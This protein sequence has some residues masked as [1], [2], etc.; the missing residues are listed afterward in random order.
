MIPLEVYKDFLLRINKNDINKNISVPRGEF[1]LLFNEQRLLWLDIAIENNESSDKI[2]DISE[3]YEP[4][5]ELVR[6]VDKDFSSEFSLPINYF[7]KASVYCLASKDECKDVVMVAWNFKPKNKNFNIQ[8]SNEDP[9]FEYQ[10]TKFSVA[11]NKLILYKTDFNIDKVYLSYYREPIALDIEGYKHLDGTISTNVQTDL[12][13]INIHKVLDKC[14]AV[15]LGRYQNTEGFQI[16]S[17][18]EA[19]SK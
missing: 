5:K 18:L 7:D 4:D 11:S 2:D 19:K 16:A 1:V 9:S 12:I 10:E 14:A 6:I 8:N 3:L 13:D 15:V 17:N